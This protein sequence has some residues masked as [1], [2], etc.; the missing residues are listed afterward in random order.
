MSSTTIAIS[1]HSIRN[2][3]TLSV[4]DRSHLMNHADA[5][6]R[7]G[8][9][10]DGLP[11]VLRVS[12][13]ASIVEPLLRALH[14]PDVDALSKEIRAHL[15]GLNRQVQSERRGLGIAARGPFVDAPHY[16]TMSSVPA[17]MGDT[18][19]ARMLGP[20][21]P[22]LLPEDTPSWQRDD[23]VAAKTSCG[24]LMNPAEFQQLKREFATHQHLCVPLDDSLPAIVR[25][26]PGK[27][28]DLTEGR[29][30]V[31]EDLRRLS[32]TRFHGYRRVD[33]AVQG[34]DFVG[35][36]G[37][38][39]AYRR[40]VRRADTVGWSVTRT[41]LLRVV[42]EVARSLVPLHD[43]GV[44]HGDIK[45]ANVFITAE[46]AVAHDSLD[47]KAGA[48]S[49]AGTKGWNAPEQIIARPCSPATDVFA[50]SQLVVR[51]LEAAVFGD[52]R[53]FVVPIGN[54]QR[55]RERMIAI[56]DVFI[57]PTMIPLDEAGLAAWR[58]FLRR[59]LV[60]D[61]DKRVRD[62]ATFANELEQLV[63]RHP[64]GGRRAVSRLTGQLVRNARG[65]GLVDRARRAL[66]GD[67]GS[68]VWMLDDSYAYVH[69]APWHFLLEVAA[70]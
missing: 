68:V 49:A 17:L 66:G 35:E 14:A 20:T 61:A 45:P 44:V 60:L 28:L 24:V 11:L 48:L 18:L 36:L 64:V 9:A 19:L 47:I 55:I 31:C 22:L 3:E 33:G 40:A 50:L 10:P 38:H 23:A 29:P 52:E 5:C 16:V 27:S 69:R 1:W 30:F 58:A 65:S 67:D 25:Q 39:E 37:D 51:I 2:D 13:A 26:G 8:T 6:I 53:S 56:P 42:V 7:I 54:G 70:A 62:A 63:A 41:D 34:E 4:H 15:I 21:S 59:C 32:S 12:R 46:G 57:D 43:D